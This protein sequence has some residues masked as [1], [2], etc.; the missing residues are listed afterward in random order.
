MKQQEKLSPSLEDFLEAIYLM[1]RDQGEA[2]P[3]YLKERFD[4]TDYLITEILKLLIEKELIIRSPGD[5]V[6]LTPKGE[7]I[8][9]EVLYRH[10]TLRNFFIEV[11]GIDYETADEGACKIEH[12]VS[13][14]IIELMI[15]YTCYLKEKPDQSGSG[16]VLSFEEYL[17]NDKK[18]TCASIKL[19]DSKNI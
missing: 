17:K 3:E 12:V 6:T 18:R 19:G 1:S 15:K 2:R 9:G 14:D 4:S 7:K 10:E 8:A 11:L 16:K 5:S 13:S